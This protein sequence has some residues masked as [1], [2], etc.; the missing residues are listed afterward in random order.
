MSPG[1]SVWWTGL[2]FREGGFDSRWG[3]VA[4][5]EAALVGR[6][7]TAVKRKFPDALIQKLHGGPYQTAGLPDLIIVI[8]GRIYGFEVKQ[9][10]LGER[11]EHAYERAP[12]LQNA[13]LAHLRR[14]GGDAP[15]ALR[16]PATLAPPPD[17]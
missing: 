13:P 6:V 11:P 9:Q 16:V 12:I 14:T 4:Q 2:Q 5:P 17:S 15:V 7:L 3:L 10:R 8:E 1:R